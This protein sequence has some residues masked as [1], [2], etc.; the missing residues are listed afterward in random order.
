MGLDFRSIH[1]DKLNNPDWYNADQWQNQKPDRN[2]DHRRVFN[3][4][5]YQR[6]GTELPFESGKPI[7]LVIDLL[8]RQK[9]CTSGSRGDCKRTKG[10]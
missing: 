5:F 7:A 2:N 1:K 9:W 6:F 8:A 10:R 3:Q 4:R